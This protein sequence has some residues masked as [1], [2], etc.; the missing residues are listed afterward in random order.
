MMPLAYYQEYDEVI[1]DLCQ[2]FLDLCPPEVDAEARHKGYEPTYFAGNFPAAAAF[3][4]PF[5]DEPHRVDNTMQP[6]VVN[7]GFRLFLPA[8]Y[9][10]ESGYD[11]SPRSGAQLEALRLHGRFRQNL[12][13]D[14]EGGNFNMQGRVNRIQLLRGESGDMNRLGFAIATDIS[15]EG[16]TTILWVHHTDI[17]VE[18]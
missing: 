7:I 18:L 1:L 12:Y 16:L 10:T 11:A 2:H 15:D 9:E 6:G 4:M 5:E 8:L 3:E 17:R 13:A 14:P